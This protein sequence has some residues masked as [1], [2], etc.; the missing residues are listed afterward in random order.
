MARA[1]AVIL[2][3]ALSAVPGAR[4]AGAA[5]AGDCD[6][7]GSV[8]INELVRAVAIALGSTALDQCAAADSDG[9]GSVT[10]A[11]L[12]GAVGVA[13]GGCTA[14]ATP[15]PSGTPGRTATATEAAAPTATPTEGAP[16]GIAWHRD[17]TL[18]N[19][20]FPGGDSTSMFLYVAVDG[21][22]AET[23]QVTLSG[24][25]GGTATLQF[26]ANET[27]GGATYS[28]FF[29]S[30][31]GIPYVAG[32]SYTLTTVTAAG[33]ASASFVAPG[34]IT[35]AADGAQA[36]W[37]HDGT[38]ETIVVASPATWS[39]GPG[40][41]T[42]PF[43]IPAEAYGAGVVP[44]RIGV[45]V[46]ATITAIAG[47]A[48]GSS[49]TVSDG[50]YADVVPSAVGPTFTPTRTGTATPTATPSPSRTPSP[51]FTGTLAPTP[52]LTG[53]ILFTSNRAG[54]SPQVF[55]MDATGANAVQ[56]TSVDAF[57]SSPQWSPD[58]SRIAF[59]RDGR[60]HLMNADGSGVTAL[61][62]T[63]SQFDPTF[64]PDGTR[65][66]FAELDAFKTRLVSYDLATGAATPLTD[67]VAND[68]G[69]TFSP[70]GQHVFFTSTRDSIY[71]EIYRIDADGSNFVRLTNNA[72]YEQLGE[73]SPDGTRLAYAARDAFRSVSLGIVV[74]AVDASAPVLLTSTA[75]RVDDEH[76][77]WSP[78]GAYLLFRPHVDG[79]NR[80]YRMQADGTYVTDLSPAGASEV[81]SDWR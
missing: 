69:P 26:G 17:S 27:R 55:V 78:D 6:G 5:C 81:A 54:G 45:I 56:L 37:V 75:D 73:V 72:D 23:A 61:R 71:G 59:T 28:Q 58:K 19:V 35:V 65:I 46:D 68:A 43:A 2:M 70:D 32:A 41:R 66:V 30:P 18:Q 29:A 64:S 77:L 10:I 62:T 4:R 38:A 20:R 9:N 22:A 44:Y 48:A 8:A 36:S 33:T 67:A 15:T 1:L 12:I 49:F 63:L 13:L 42:S 31:L 21:Q 47:A 53:E 52:A 14:A 25:G 16:P 39:S 60:L 40:D 74:A 50:L 11:E 34:G 79:N 7:D 57:H 3:V 80:I 24:P 51:T 76:P